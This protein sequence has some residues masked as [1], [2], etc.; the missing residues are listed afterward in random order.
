MGRIGVDAGV[1]HRQKETNRHNFKAHVHEEITCL[2]DMIG[3][4]SVTES[5]R[6][7]RHHIFIAVMTFP[8]VL[9]SSLSELTAP[10]MSHSSGPTLPLSPPPPDAS[11]AVTLNCLSALPYVP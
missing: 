11:V 4:D 6:F 3:V 10:R 2:E 8:F 7:C 1:E 5:W 9:F